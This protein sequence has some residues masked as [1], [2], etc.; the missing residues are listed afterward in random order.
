MGIVEYVNS[1]GSVIIS[2]GG[3]HLAPDNDYCNIGL[4]SSISDY[5]NVMGLHTM[6]GYVDLG[7]PF[8]N[9]SDPPVLDNVTVSNI[10]YRGYN[11][12]CT[13]SDNTGVARVA[14]PTWTDNGLDETSNQDDL[15]WHQGTVEGNT[16]S[17]WIPTA[18][19]NNETGCNYITDV[20]VYDAAGNHAPVQRVVASIPAF[21]EELIDPIVYN[22]DFYRA[23]Y[24]DLAARFGDDDVALM[25]HWI[26]TGIAEKRTASP[27]F[28]IGHYLDFYPPL[29][30]AFGNDYVSAIKH[31]VN[32]GAA[33]GRYASSEFEINCYKAN[34]YDLQQA[35]GDDNY[36]YYKH[37]VLF[38]RSE[39][40]TA[41]HRISATLNPC[42]GTVSPASIPVT[43]YTNYGELPQ[44]EKPDSLF[45]GWFTEETG[46]TQITDTSAVESLT[47]HTLYAHWSE[48]IAL[49]VLGPVH[50][51]MTGHI[52]SKDEL[53]YVALAYDNGMSVEIEAFLLEQS[54][55]GE[56]TQTLTI[57]YG[58]FRRP[59]KWR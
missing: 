17:I 19:H 41:D 44:P 51:Y 55:A 45:T 33:E 13:V 22:S 6:I 1:D 30:T 12:S 7:V 5:Q 46:G 27:V 39:G 52:F 25:D 35:Y 8:T 54:D 34:Y 15:I 18:E 58:R 24:P 14:F 26:G 50:Q 57:T 42:G 31:F 10:T 38:G 36:E 48:P 40:R 11:V 16:A 3:C 37:Y 21:S 28:N 47:D 20:Y 59:S 23:T 56:N 4:Y 49:L 2:D 32:Y 9:D 53:G 29:E 43:S